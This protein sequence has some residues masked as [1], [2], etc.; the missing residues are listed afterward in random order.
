MTTYSYLL[1]LVATT[2]AG[3]LCGQAIP[4]RPPE[5]ERRIAGACGT[6]SLDGIIYG[7]APAGRLRAH[8]TGVQFTPALGQAAE[9][10][11]C[12]HLSLQSITR[13]ASLVMESEAVEPVADGDTIR[14]H[15]GAVEERYAMRGD[16]IEQSFVF[17]TEPGGTGDLVVTCKLTS[18]LVARPTDQGG[19]AFT[20]HGRCVAT[21]GGVTGIDHD[22][23]RVRGQLRLRGER[24]ELVLPADFVDHAAYPLTLDPL[25]GVPTLPTGAG[26]DADP[27]LAYDTTNN[28]WL[29]VWK[30]TISAAESDIL[31]LRLANDGSPIGTVFPIDT[32]ASVVRR[33]P[34]VANQD[35]RDTFVVVHSFANSPFAAADLSA[36]SVQAATGVVS[37]ALPFAQTVADET[38]PCIGGNAAS[39]GPTQSNVVVCWQRDGVAVEARSLVVQQ[40]PLQPVLGSSTVV[41]AS[42]LASQPAIGHSGGTTG[43]PLWPVAFVSTS[44]G[45]AE[46]EVLAIDGLAQPVAQARGLTRNVAIDDLE[47][48]VDGDGSNCLVAWVRSTTSSREL[49]GRRIAVS[50]A[51]A[52][53]VGSEIVIADD[54]TGA[55]TRPCVAWLGNGF[56]VVWEVV[57]SV[58]DADAFAQ[59][60]TAFGEL[61]GPPLELIGPARPGS[62]TRQRAPRVGSRSHGAPVQNDGFVVFGEA[63]SVVGFEQDVVLQPIAAMGA[64]GA[65]VITPTTCGPAGTMAVHGPVAL[66]NADFRFELT[67]ADP[68]AAFALLS[69]GFTNTPLSCGTCALLPGQSLEFVALTAG[70]A[71]RPFPLPCAASFLGLP[72]VAQWLVFGANTTACPLAPGLAASAIATV[73]VGL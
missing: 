57:R 38:L 48:A 55:E 29:L 56:A 36:R 47:P 61:C 63:Q 22:G 66:G 35:F 52:A 27:D 17:A 13:G 49:V 9:R 30:R 11:L 10:A 64:G 20:D 26:D 62:Y 18:A 42:S 72:L 2:L 46:I 31:G 5:P 7:I 60:V 39:S 28:L 34:R 58:L 32:A 12:I 1:C 43:A 19:L 53:P 14:Y 59:I 69:L 6:G 37:S 50:A 3:A 45:D 51:G 70:N 16:G 67:G 68:A 15:R 21:M 73:V 71:V 54:G 25:L 40:A 65:V 41:L 8:R 4:S 44:T 33:H 23:V 24:L